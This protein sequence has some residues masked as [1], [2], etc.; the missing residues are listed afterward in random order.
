[1]MHPDQIYR[2]AQDRTADL[3]RRRARAAAG[4][5]VRAAA[6]IG[7]PRPPHGWRHATASLLRIVAERLDPARPGGPADGHRPRPHAA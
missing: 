6:R 5:R 3:R 2:A 7:D 1:M 4:A